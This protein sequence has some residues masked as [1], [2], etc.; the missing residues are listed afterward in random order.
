MQP[1]ASV[2]VPAWTSRPG[3][4]RL[5]LSVAAVLLA[6]SL[7]TVSAWAITVRD[8]IELSRAGVTEDVLVELIEMDGSVPPLG[9]ADL[10]ELKAAGVSDRVVITMLRLARIERERR[11][12]RERVAEEERAEALRAANAIL[13]ASPSVVVG[14]A[15][16]ERLP[17]RAL[18]GE[19]VAVPVPVIV[20]VYIQ[21]IVEVDS[22][23]TRRSSQPDDSPRRPQP[24][25]RSASQS[26]GGDDDRGRAN[27]EKAF[28][29]VK[30]SGWIV[31]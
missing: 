3:Q 7:G 27:G 26:R 6:L 9:L 20:P 31:R 18:V 29:I 28:W 10:L 17:S 16:A 11:E 5:G 15:V 1:T 24:E 8:V 19:P 12:Q 22:S 21:Q 13:E 23:R 25:R 2:P 4:L 30:S 14:D